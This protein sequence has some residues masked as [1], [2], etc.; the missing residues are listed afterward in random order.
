MDA[1]I[2]GRRCRGATLIDLLVIVG[3]VLILAAI[4]TPVLLGLRGC[5]PDYAS[6]ERIGTVY[7]LSRKGLIFKSWE[8]E[9]MLTTLPV[10]GGA[11]GMLPGVLFPFS[12]TD[13]KVAAMLNDALVANR[14]VVLKYNGWLIGPCWISTDH[15]V[16]DVVPSVK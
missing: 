11:S 12:T 7:K 6:G 2:W 3:I 14:Q 9:A 15:E 5:S 16:T 4:V 8:G 1:N 10:N 13:D